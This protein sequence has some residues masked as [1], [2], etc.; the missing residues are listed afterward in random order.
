MRSVGIIGGGLAGVALAA[1]LGGRGHAVTV[2]ERDRAGGKLRREQVGAVTFD[3]GPSLFT[4]PEVWRAYVERVGEPDPLDLRPLPGGLGVHH[5]PF[6]PVPLPVPPDHPLHPHWRSYVRTAAPLRPHL[7]TLLTTPPRVTDPAFL[8]AARALFGVTGRHPT[9][10]AWLRAQ[11]LPPALEHALATH[12]LNAGVTPWDAP[13]LYALIPALLDGQVYRPAAGMGALL[14]TLLALAGRRGVVIR[15]GCAVTGLRATTLEL[16]GGETV[17]HDVL[18]SAIDPTRLAALRR[19]STRSPVGR[20]TVSGFV[21]YGV[22]DRP[23]PLPYTSIVPPDDFRALRRALRAGALPDSTLTMVHHDPPRV[24]VLISMPAT[25]AAPSPDHP[26]V[27]AELRRVARRL[28]VPDLLPALRDARTLTPAHY[29]LGGHPGG[30][31]YGAAAPA[32]RAGP[33]H[34]Q[35]YHVAPGLWQVGTGVHPGGGIPAILGGALIVNTLM[36]ERDR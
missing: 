25:G 2:Y 7:T 23:L 9:A 16:D 33:L 26:W 31:I 27:Q 22:L 12:A 4:F 21:L 10:H 35:P 28:D 29:V 3:T 11:R 36:A 13:A 18:V 30:A 17:R 15:T 6:G 20:R 24:T 8:R 34:P 19:H 5:T 14:D 1:L 32:W